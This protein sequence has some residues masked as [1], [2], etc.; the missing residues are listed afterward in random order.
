MKK[1]CLGFLTLFSMQAMAHS[2]AH[3]HAELSLDNVLAWFSH[4]FASEHH[5]AQ[6]L[7]LAAVLLTMVSLYK[8]KAVKGLRRSKITQSK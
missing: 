6:W 3:T 4:M 5:V 1:Q 7:L 8:L 2:G